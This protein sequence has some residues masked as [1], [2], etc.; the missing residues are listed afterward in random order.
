[1][2]IRVTTQDIAKGK[3]PSECPIARAARRILGKQVRVGTD[4]IWLGNFKKVALP[5]HVQNWI[6]RF[7]TDKSVEPFV[8]QVRMPR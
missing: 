5:E 1:M 6:R 7:D 2:W 3:L 8:F 4:A